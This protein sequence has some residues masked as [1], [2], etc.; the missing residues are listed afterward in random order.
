V[1]EARAKKKK[2]RQKKTK[3]RKLSCHTHEKRGEEV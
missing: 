1:K 3:K 2:R